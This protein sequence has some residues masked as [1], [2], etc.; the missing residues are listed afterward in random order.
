MSDLTKVT[1]NLP[2]NELEALR[3]L[4]ARRGSTVTSTLRKAIDT[5]VFLD[6]Q[7][8]KGAKIL[9]EE[10]NGTFSRVIRR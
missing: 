2:N 4:A 5:E 10:P 9:I 7:E 3:S 1:F 6:E 8:R